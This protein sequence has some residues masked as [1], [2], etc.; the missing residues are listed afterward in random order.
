MSSDIRSAPAAEPAN[1][2]DGD[3][4]AAW[5]DNI[6]TVVAATIGVLIV[7]LIAVLMGMA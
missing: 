4:R 7:A 6:V 5:R 2:T 1:L 3:L